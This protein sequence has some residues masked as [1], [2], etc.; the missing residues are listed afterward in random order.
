MEG[1]ADVG[2]AH[3]ST[4]PFHTT[5]T[6][7]SSLSS[8]VY[9][10]HNFGVQHQQGDSGYSKPARTGGEHSDTEIETLEELNKLSLTH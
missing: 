1:W 6:A 3:S 9:W 4:P 7:S 8:T 10:K 5:L 2:T